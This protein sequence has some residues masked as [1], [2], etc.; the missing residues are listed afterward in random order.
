MNAVS[1]ALFGLGD[2]YAQYLRAFV[3]AHANL[4]PQHQDGGGWHLRVHYSDDVDARW[5]D[6]LDR[7]ACKGLLSTVRMEKRPLTAAMLWRL[8][9]CFYPDFRYVF[10]RDLDAL[11]TPRDRAVCDQFIAS[12]CMV[13]TVHDNQYHV[14]MMG[15]LCGFFA[16]ALREV[17]GW[18]NLNDVY[19][20][21]RDA[22]WGMHGVDQNVL[23]QLVAGNSAVKLLESRFAG[24]HAGPGVHAARG[25]GHYPCQ[26]WSTPVPD[27]GTSA[28]S[29][30]L[31][32]R[33]DRLANHMG[34]AGYDHEA[35]RKFW[36]TNGDAEVTRRVFE[37]EE[38]W[39]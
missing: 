39:K 1:L 35:A 13:H 12:G 4:F 17:M 33:A 32:A 24:W 3:I 28:L 36:M 8:A 6:L 29:P 31:S 14:G 21:A 5:L 19:Q 37:A 11:P 7:Y 22:Q 16:P 20:N 9:P 30:E 10:C 25:P 38:G 27:V 26:A 18:K 23:N 34:A 15:G 2:K